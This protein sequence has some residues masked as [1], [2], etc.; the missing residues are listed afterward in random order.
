MQLNRRDALKLGGVTVAGGAALAAAGCSPGK[1]GKVATKSLSRLS[2][3][4]FPKPYVNVIAK[5]PPAE[6]KMLDGVAT[7]DI[8]MKRNPGLPILSPTL[9]TPVFGYDGVFPGPRIELNRGTTAKITHRN[10]LPVPGIFGSPSLTSVH[11]HGSASLPEFDG[12]ANDKTAPGQMKD[13]HYPNFQS[14]RTLWYH[15]HGV[16]WTSQQAYGGLAGLYVMHDKQE[17]TLLPTGEFD[18]PLVVNDAMFAADG[19]LAWDDNSHSGLW[20]DVI[21]VNGAPWPVMKVQRRTYRF[22]ILDASISRSY[23]WKLSNGLPLQV[24]AT[25]GGLMPKGVAVPEFRHLGGERYEVVIDFGKVPANI[26]RV[27]LGN[28]SNKNNRDYDNTNKVMAFDLLDTPVTKTRANFDDPTVQEPDP[29][30]NRNYAGFALVPSDIMSLPATGNY[31]RRRLS[32]SRS[33]GEWQIQDHTWMDVEASNFNKVVGQPADWDAVEI[34]EI[35]N[36]S[37]GWYHPLHIHLLDFRIIKRTGGPA[38]GVNGVLPHEQGPKDVAYIGEGETVT[39]LCK[40]IKPGGDVAAP[41]GDPAIKGGRWMTHCHNLAHEDH[42]MMSQFR[43]GAILAN[44]PHHPINAA[45]PV[46]D[47]TYKA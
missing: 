23:R 11:L 37:G 35:V 36:N 34:W 4:N 10:H 43:V 41:A 44:D 14:A 29:T 21:L 33:N 15:D 5:T 30:W 45:K 38:G 13:Y 27:T 46:A 17:S 24:V 42:D 12:Y 3:A 47:P 25:D 2:A 26:K 9:L 16:H 20:G 28:L 32:L 22:R 8:T 6:A 18:V 7:Y 1:E 40:F 39:L 19:S 31:A